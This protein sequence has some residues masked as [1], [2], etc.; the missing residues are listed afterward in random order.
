LSCQGIDILEIILDKFLY[1]SFEFEALGFVATGES[2]YFIF[3][4]ID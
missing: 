3:V 2:G 4:G 1:S